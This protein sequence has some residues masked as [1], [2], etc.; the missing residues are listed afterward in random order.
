[1]TGP[2]RSAGMRGDPRN[3]RPEA[4]ISSTRPPPRGETPAA[5]APASRSR[6]PKPQILMGE[7]VAPRGIEI[8][9]GRDALRAFML[10]HRLVPTRWAEAAGVPAGEILAYLTG[11]TRLLSQA[12]VAKLASAANVAPEEMFADKKNGG[13]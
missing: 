10:A 5:A 12:T 2:R 1:M 13:P 6:H 4:E 11:R 3:P 9:A 7:V 8:G